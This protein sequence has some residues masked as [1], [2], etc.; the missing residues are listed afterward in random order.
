MAGAAEPPFAGD[1]GGD[2]LADLRFARLSTSSVMLGL[3]EHVDEAGGDDVVAHLDAAPRVARERSPMAAIW[4]PLDP[5]VGAEP[6]RTGAVDHPPAGDHEV[7]FGGVCDHAA[8]AAS[9]T[10]PIA[11]T[12]T[13]LISRTSRGKA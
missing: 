10:P 3:A 5:D 1:L 11:D 6:G 2:P 9:T 12:R 13:L 8:A 7:E 4:S